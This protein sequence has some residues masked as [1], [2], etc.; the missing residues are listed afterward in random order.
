M[1]QYCFCI[2]Q[3]VRI[4][5][6]IPPAGPS[7]SQ[8]EPRNGYFKVKFTRHNDSIWMFFALECNSAI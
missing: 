5:G 2:R 8:D 3:T 7:S 4:P 6:G 1:S